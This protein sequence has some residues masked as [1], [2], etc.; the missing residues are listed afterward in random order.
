MAFTLSTPLLFSPQLHFKHF[1]PISAAKL[2]LAATPPPQKTGS[3]Y[4]SSK[5]LQPKDVNIFNPVP[6]IEALF[7]TYC[8]VLWNPSLLCFLFFFLPILFSH[9]CCPILHFLLHFF[10]QMHLSLIS[11]VQKLS[12]THE[13]LCTTNN[14]RIHHA[15]FQGTQQ[16]AGLLQVADTIN[17]FKYWCK[18]H[19]FCYTPTLALWLIAAHGP[20]H[21][22]LSVQK[23]NII[24]RWS[25]K[26]PSNSFNYLTARPM[27]YFYYTV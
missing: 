12:C 26:A 19:S 5:F 10:S 24:R 7:F 23:K 13:T 22:A 8:T 3:A 17:R 16:V 2:E 4:K 9:I 27:T 1:F 11:M 21:W 6:N 20:T 14:K 18:E 15:V 25:S